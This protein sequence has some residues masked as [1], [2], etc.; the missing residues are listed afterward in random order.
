Y[1]GLLEN[2]T[3]ATATVRDILTLPD[4]AAHTA[5]ILAGQCFA[6]SNRI[7]DAVRQECSARLQRAFDA[8]T[9]ALTFIQLASVLA[10]IGG[11]DVARYFE[12]VLDNANVNV[13]VIAAQALGALGK[14]LPPPRILMVLQTALRD[15]EPTVRRAA[16]VSLG[17][18]GYDS[19][20]ITEALHTLC[21]NDDTPTV[22]AAAVSL[23]A[24]LGHAADLTLVKI[25]AGEFTMGSDGGRDNEKPPHQI[26]LDEYY[27][28]RYPVTNAE[29]G[30]FVQ[31]GGY[32]Q[33]Q[34]W[35]EDGWNWKGN[36]TSPEKYGGVF[37]HPNHPVVG[38]TWYEAV[39][40]ATWAGMR[41]PTEAEWEKA[42]C[43][44]DGRR[45]PWGDTFD[46]SRCNSTESRAGARGIL[47]RVGALFRRP[48]AESATTPVGQYSPKGDSPYGVADMAG[49]VW[50]WC[51]DWHDADYYRNSPTQNPKGPGSG[52]YRV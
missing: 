39:A 20:G 7:N 24:R 42:A 28:A 23:L 26:Y 40:Y 27:I 13:R 18:L 52:D 5:L 22:R 44:T 36:R 9:D 41:L 1:I 19:A 16:I 4:D 11:E 47:A 15:Q 14:R 50:E 30:R 46:A 29:F 45:Y 33:R 3:L 49:N 34:W 43:G 25:P 48:G 10:S 8:T 17:Q 32:S 31:A 38:V 6:E 2:D 12:R 37:D 21:E 35:T 51:A